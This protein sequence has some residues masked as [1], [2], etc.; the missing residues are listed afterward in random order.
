MPKVTPPTTILDVVLDDLQAEL[1]LLGIHAGYEDGLWRYG[2]LADDLIRWCPDWILSRQEIAEFSTSNGVDLIAKALDR[3]YKTKKPEKRGEIGELLLHIAMRSFFGSER[4][5]SRIYFKDASN[6]T[7]KG[8]DAAHVVETHDGRLELW[9]GESKFYPN[10]ARAASDVMSGLIIHLQAGYLRSEFLAISDKLESDWEHTA[11]VKSLLQKQ[12]SL[13]EVFDRI[14]VPVF[15]T[16]NSTATALH[17]KLSDAYTTLLKGEL[18]AR[19]ESFISKHQAVVLPREVKLV[20]ILLPM[21][22]KSEMTKKFDE[23]LKAWQAVLNA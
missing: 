5:I 9:L 16:Y 22:K 2:A 18:V 6:D 11:A 15:I 13:D 17:N 12:R 4:A 7:V 3:V 19:W 8:F 21:P 10:V 20:L 23:R 1:P 14:V